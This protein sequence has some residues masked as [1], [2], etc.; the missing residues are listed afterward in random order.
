MTGYLSGFHVNHWLDPKQ[1]K[2]VTNDPCC[3]FKLSI[4]C[5]EFLWR[6]RNG[7]A[8]PSGPMAIWTAVQ[9]LDFRQIPSK[10]LIG[11]KSYAVCESLGITPDLL[12]LGH[13]LLKHCCVMRT[14]WPISIHAFWTLN[15]HSSLV[16]HSQGAFLI[17]IC[18]LV[19]AKFQLFPVETHILLL[20]LWVL[21]NDCNRSDFLC[22]VDTFFRVLR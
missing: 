7:I 12:I 6:D 22:H 11:L 14:D 17:L 10:L 15:N 5:A 16:K 8:H 1:I 19:V 3:P 4:K 13:A 2:V 18:F 20:T 21:G 9:L